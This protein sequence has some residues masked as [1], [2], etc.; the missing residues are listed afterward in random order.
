MYI[1][2][3]LLTC[4]PEPQRQFEIAFK[5]MDADGSNYIDKSEFLQVWLYSIFMQYIGAS[6]Y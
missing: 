3:S 5:M 1:L 4:A 2:I 6:F